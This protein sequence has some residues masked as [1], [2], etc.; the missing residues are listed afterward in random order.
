MG[1]SHD[2]MLQLFVCV[3]GEGSCCYRRV[4]IG[5]Q[6]LRMNW[7]SLRAVMH[8]FTIHYYS[9]WVWDMCC[10]DPYG[11]GSYENYF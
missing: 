10:S 5:H 6:S 7:A 2:L 9:F 4:V 1:E 11:G 3:R 8:I